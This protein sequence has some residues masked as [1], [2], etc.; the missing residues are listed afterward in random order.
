[1]NA[2][3]LARGIEAG[4]SLK[5]VP[6]VELTVAYTWSDS[7]DSTLQQRV[8]GVP[9]HRGQVAFLFDPLPAWQARVGWRIESDQLDAALF[10]GK[11]H[12]PGFV[13]MDA[14]TRYLLKLKGS[15]TREIALTGK[16]QNLLGH[17]Y[18]ERLDNPSPGINF[19]IGAEL[20]I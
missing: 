7:W 19:I 12:R 14:S 8:L 13:V 6:E 16:V 11:T 18:E 20:K 1:V 10:S 17:R 2:D 9:E 15:G 5:I 4:L 3:A